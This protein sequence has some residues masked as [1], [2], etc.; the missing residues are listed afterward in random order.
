MSCVNRV[1]SNKKVD[2]SELYFACPIDNQMSNS[3][4]YPHLHFIMQIYDVQLEFTVKY[5]V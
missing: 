5:I 2:F 4:L 1:F 3:S